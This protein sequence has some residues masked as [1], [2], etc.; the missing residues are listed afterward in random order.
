MIEI[1]EERPADHEAVRAVNDQAF[2]QPAEGRIVDAI[3]A[4]CDET[5]SLVATSGG[6]VV[7][8]IFF[9]PAT[10]ETDDRR[11]VGMGLAPMAVLPD[12]QHQGIGSRLVEE[13]LRRIRATSCPFVV[14]LGHPDYYP[15][16]GFEPASRYD[17]RSQWDGIPDEAFMAMILDPSVMAGVA[18]VVSYR[19][20]FDAAM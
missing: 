13:G 2:E 9:S 18:G 16:F 8:H 6:Q 7:G 1:R 10:I 17:L 12:R 14:V 4:A 20:E 3:R 19:S 5:L 15:R 11:I